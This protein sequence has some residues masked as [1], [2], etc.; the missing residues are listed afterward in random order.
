MCN[1][2]K[3]FISYSW[4]SES[5]QKEVLA[6]ANRLRQ[7][8]IDCQIDQYVEHPEKTW[9]NWMQD[10]IEEANF[11]IIVCTEL[12]NKRFRQKEEGG[13]GRGVTFEGMIIQAHIY[14]KFCK[15]KKFIPVVLC[16]TDE[17]HIPTILSGGNR[18]RLDTEEGYLEMYRYL[19][20]QREQV[21]FVRTNV[22]NKYFLK[23]IIEISTPMFKYLRNIFS[24]PLRS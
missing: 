24:F 11:V 16:R 20:N 10:R 17:N 13:Q 19:T 1:P 4:D 2:P 14:E 6:Q 23:H 3:V 9:L 18:Y 8:G 7:Q 22:L 21:T 5:H 15:N 12:Y